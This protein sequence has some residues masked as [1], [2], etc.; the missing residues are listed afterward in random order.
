MNRQLSVFRY[1]EGGF[2]RFHRIAEGG[3]ED[4]SSIY[5]HGAKYGNGGFTGQR[6]ML[7]LDG[8]FKGQRV[9]FR[10]DDHL[11]RLA[12]TAQ[13]LEWFELPFSLDAV[14]QAMF[15]LMAVNTE[16]DYFSLVFASGGDVG[17]MPKG[18]VEHHIFMNS[19]DFSQEHS[20]LPVEVLRHGMTVRLTEPDIRRG[21]PSK[22]T[23]AKVSGNYA[24]SNVAKFRA[25]QAGADDALMLDHT[26]N[27]VAELSVAN[28]LALFDDTLIT[29]N[30]SSGALNGITKQTVMAMAEELYGSKTNH[31]PI[32]VTLLRHARMMIATGTAIG[33]CKIRRLVDAKSQVIWE[34]PDN[35]PQAS[36]LADNLTAGIWRVMRGQEGAD[37]HPEWF[38]PIPEH[39]LREQQ[40]KLQFA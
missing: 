31:D 37:F 19:R 28:F 11:R 30:G 36:T 23:Q 25:Q 34:Q 27:N 9:F 38:T 2:G 16:D 26:G 24:A 22:L 10:L 35:D 8:P 1:G 14:R 32:P 33:A 29:P 4:V 17:V 12:T 20:Y 13:A 7:H 18:S 21:I 15:E 5:R 39:L 3:P 40:L 6:C